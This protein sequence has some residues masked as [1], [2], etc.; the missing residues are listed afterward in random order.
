MRLGLW[1][2]LL[3]LF[4]L[5]RV[6]VGMCTAVSYGG[7]FSSKHKNRSGGSKSSSKSS[8]S[9][10]RRGKRKAASTKSES[11]KEEK[12]RRRR[13]RKKRSKS[14]KED[15]NQEH[16]T[17]PGVYDALKNTLQDEINRDRHEPITIPGQ[18]SK[19]QLKQ[20]SRQLVKSLE[21]DVEHEVGKY[22]EPPQ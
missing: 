15:D 17:H 1:T 6:N 4:A 8:K 3:L 10:K 20:I 13:F 7:I 19:E 2:G 18:V 14:E 16:E 5:F 9:S 22:L 11:K 12:K 21:K